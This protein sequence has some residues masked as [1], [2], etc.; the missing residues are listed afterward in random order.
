MDRPRC[1]LVWVGGAICF[2]RYGLALLRCRALR[3][4][5]CTSCHS[6]F[7]SHN[8]R[9]CLNKSPLREKRRFFFFKKKLKNI[10]GKFGPIANMHTQPGARDWR[11]CLKACALACKSRHW[12]HTSSSLGW[13]IRRA[14]G[15]GS[16]GRDGRA[17]LIDPPQFLSTSEFFYGVG[18][19]TSSRIMSADMAIGIRH[20]AHGAWHLALGTWHLALG[21]W[22]LALG[23]GALGTG[24]L[25]L[26][27]HGVWRKKC[28][29]ALISKKKKGASP[30]IKKRRAPI[31]IKKAG[32]KNISERPGAKNIPRKRERQPTTLKKKT[33]Q[34]R[35]YSS[36]T[37]ITQAKR[38]CPCAKAGHG[39]GRP[40]SS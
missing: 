15:L 30:H 18:M 27:A 28:A 4:A 36:P 39:Q 20:M 35:G 9:R 8:V 21:T 25:G 12:S 40:I 17:R 3:H 14:A 37:H 32:R 1:L 22:H 7:L 38:R 34:I 29:L 16:C 10:F 19:I 2:V 26:M 5:P 33:T 6:T 31:L 11:A 23:T 24:A 13:S